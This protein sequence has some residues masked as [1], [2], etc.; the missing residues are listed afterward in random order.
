MKR[1]SIFLVLTFVLTYLFEFLVIAPMSGDTSLA[2]QSVAK[3]LVSVVMFIPALG[4][5]LT[6]LLTKEGFGNVMLKPNIKSHWKYYLFAWFVPQLL[7]AIGAIVY[8]LIFPDRFDPQHGYVVEQYEAT[9]VTLTPKLL[10][11]TMISQF[12]MA[13]FLAPLLNGVVCFGEEWG[14]RGYMMPKLLEKLSFVPSVLVGGIIW[15]LWHAPLIAMGHNYGTEYIGSPW[16]G[17][18]MMCLFCVVIGTILTW[19][20]IRTNSVWAAVIAH[21]AINGF[22]AAPLFFV[23]DNT[24]SL[25]GPTATG[26]LGMSAFIVVAVIVC[27]KARNYSA[28]QSLDE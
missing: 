8:F 7:C 18:T 28:Q 6:R 22:A 24:H 10:N 27:V 5:V 14:W 2:N 23:A 12:A 3:I 1:L 4:V 25:I 16:T 13:I 21:G 9:G 11:I 17:I 20:T 26:L 15:G 19:L